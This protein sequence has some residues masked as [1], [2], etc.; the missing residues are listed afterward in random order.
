MSF[1]DFNGG[2][3]CKIAAPYKRDFYLISCGA[4]HPKEIPALVQNYQ[5]QMAELEGYRVQAAIA[6]L[7][8]NDG[9][10]EESATAW[11]TAASSV[12]WLQFLP[13]DDRTKAHKIS[14]EMAELNNNY[15]AI[16]ATQM[17]Q[18]R[19]GW[20]VV[21]AEK[22]LPNATE[23]KI[24]APWFG[25]QRILCEGHRLKSLSGAVIH[26]AE[27]YR[28]D[29]VL[30]VRKLSRQLPINEPLFLLNENGGYEQGD[31]SWGQD[32]T[33]QHMTE[34][35][36]SGKTQLQQILEFY[37]AESA[38]DEVKEDAEIPLASDSA[39]LETMP[40]PTLS[41]GTK[42]TGDSLTSDAVTPDLVTT[43]SS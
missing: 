18:F 13:Q 9:Q 11:V 43:P 10:N 2:K 23:L 15:G 42:S 24:E 17:M 31:Q 6:W 12:L 36:S 8:R 21:L 32:D 4:L 41:T 37:G 33:A 19:L 27:T 34:R 39:T 3:P 20:H 30:K 16:I 1:F 28:D 7:G 35:A 26:V 14:Q 22:S 29:G 5:R 25:G 40:S 38:K